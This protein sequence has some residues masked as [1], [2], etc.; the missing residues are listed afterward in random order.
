MHRVNTM[1]GK[2]TPQSPYEIN[3]S[4]DLIESSSMIPLTLCQIT[5]PT[6]LSQL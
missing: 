1:L 5:P 2:R 4:S 3:L 6:N